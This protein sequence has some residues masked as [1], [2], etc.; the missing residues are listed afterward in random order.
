MKRHDAAEWKASPAAT[1]SL[2]ISVDGNHCRTLGL[3][4]ASAIFYAS[5]NSLPGDI[6]T[7]ADGRQ[8]RKDFVESQKGY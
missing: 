2:M 7:S 3:K 4:I 8:I 5:S 6:A 1:G